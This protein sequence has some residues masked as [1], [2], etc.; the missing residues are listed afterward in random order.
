MLKVAYILHDTDKFGGAY[1]S[2]LPMLYALMKKGVEPLVIVPIETNDRGVARDLQERGIPTLELKYRL[3]VY[4]YQETLKDYLLWIAR[5]IARRYV[6]TKAT[7]QLAEL[8][9][10]YDI[11]HSNS[12]VIDVGARAAKLAGIPHVYHFRENTDQLGMHYYPSRRSFYKIV[13]HAICTTRGVQ[14]HHDLVGKSVVIYDCIHTQPTE[15]TGDGEYLLFAGRLEYNKGV[16]ELIDAYAASRRTLPLWIAGAP[17][18]D[19]YLDMLRERVRQYGMEENVRLL[20][21]RGDVQQLMACARATIVPSYSE[22]FGR[23]LP[24]AMHAGCLTIGRNTTGTR[25]Q[26]DNGLRL[27]GDEIGLRFETTQQLTELINRVSRWTREDCEAY[28]ARAYRTVN[29]LYTQEACADA[30]MDY[31]NKIT[32]LC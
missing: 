20:G 27:T 2:F 9:K 30:I 23:I 1:K 8:L 12:S 15:R 29:E 19:A 28:T 26:L 25:E 10:G 17:L 4:P 16:E 32:R 24:E 21:P 5:L 18:E 13:T 31:Y 22:G 11:I 6:N 3:N 7:R 14:Q